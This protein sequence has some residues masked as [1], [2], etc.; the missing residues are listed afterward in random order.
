[1]KIVLQRVSKASVSVEGKTI[2]AIDDGF[3]V[4]LG[5]SD[6]DTEEIAD[7]CWMVRETKN[8]RIEDSIARLSV[9]RALEII[10]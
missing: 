7:N 8:V 6:T 9:E 3:L 5:V 1:M 10:V 4:L 2:G